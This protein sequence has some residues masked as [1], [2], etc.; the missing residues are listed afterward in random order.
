MAQYDHR[1]DV[2]VDRNLAAEPV[3]LDRLV[4]GLQHGEIV[5]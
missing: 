1:F 5:P 3:L 4:S 2:P